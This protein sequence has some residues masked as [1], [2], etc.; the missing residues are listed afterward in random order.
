[1]CG[2]PEEQTRTSIPSTVKRQAFLLSL[3]TPQGHFKHLTFKDVGFQSIGHRMWEPV[4]STRKRA[5]MSEKLPLVYRFVVVGPSL[6]QPSFNEFSSIV[7]IRANEHKQH[8]INSSE[9]YP[10]S[11]SNLVSYFTLI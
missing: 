10:K 9:R 6:P 1:M 8:K 3:Q 11:S 7:E 5:E 4:L 2:N